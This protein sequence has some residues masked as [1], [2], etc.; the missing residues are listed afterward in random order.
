MKLSMHSP[1]KIKVCE[2]AKTLAEFQV[3]AHKLDRKDLAIFLKALV[4]RSRT[5]SLEEMIPF[6]VNKRRGIPDHLS[7]AEIRRCNK[8][9]QNRL[10]YWCGNW[11]CY[12]VAMQEFDKALIDSVK[13]EIQRNRGA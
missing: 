6:Y 8:L 11:D 5:D 7:F 13:K 3:P 2:K 4:V 1:W 9:E 12:A 10:G